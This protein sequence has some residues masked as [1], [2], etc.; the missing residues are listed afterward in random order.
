MDKDLYSLFEFIKV[1]SRLREIARHNNATASR[2]ESVA[3]HSWHLALV[4]WVLHSTFE[5]EFEINIAQDK[6]IKMC[7]MHDLV[8]II[9]GDVSAWHPEK[10]VNK[11]ENEDSAAHELFSTL[12]VKLKKEFLNLWRE[13]EDSKTMEAKIA[14]GIDRINPAM[15]RLFTQQ[16]WKAVHADVEKLDKIQMPYLEFSKTLKTIYKEIKKEAINQKLLN[17]DTSDNKPY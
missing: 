2:K 7:L 3:E 17:V 13:F 16:G 10:S 11:K 12:P 14:R 8:E 1:S 15:M 9:A 5:K 6:V 4:A